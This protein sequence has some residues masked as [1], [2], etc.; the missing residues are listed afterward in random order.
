MYLMIENPGVAPVEGFMTLG[1]SLTRYAGNDSTIGQFGSGNKMAVN[2]LLRQNISPT[3]FCG[4]LRMEFFTKSRPVGGRQF[5]FVHVSMAGKDETG[6]SVRREKDT[7]FTLDYGALDWDEVSMALREFVSN[8]IDQSILTTRHF[9]QARVEVVEDNQVRAKAGHTRVFIPL[10]PEVSKFYAELGKRFLHFSQ[11]GALGER[12]L[13]KSNRNLGDRRTA[14]IYKKGVMV[15]EIDDTDLESLFDYNF[16]DELTLDECRNVDNYKCKTMAAYVLGGADANDLSAVF[17]TLLDQIPRWEHTFDNHYLNWGENENTKAKRHQNWNRAWQAAAG[18]AVLVDDDFKK[19]F[20]E[21]KG[22]RAK[23]IN[24]N[25]WMSAAR[26]NEIKTYV[27]VLCQDEIEGRQV[28]DPTPAV[29]ATLDQCWG[30]LE[31][32][33]MTRGKTKPVVKC[34]RTMM[35]AEALTRGFVRFGED[36]VYISTDIADAVTF[37]LQLTMIEELSHI[38][39]GSGDMSRD[40]QDFAFRLAT[41]ACRVVG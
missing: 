36:V 20:V 33:Q 31:G 19:D 39:T 27:Q 38:I 12:V 22:H 25:Q 14:V 9:N 17:A 21:K 2:L 24:N 6:R 29:V 40:F 28:L 16:G 18:D 15:R 4:H 5:Q 35:N 10:T 1:V 23:V 26:T 41:E 11:P 34:F 8:A 7:G 13:P 3:V 30:W 37:D 32:L